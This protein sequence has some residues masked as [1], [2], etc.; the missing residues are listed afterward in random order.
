MA[1][2][3]ARSP[4]AAARIAILTAAS[5]WAFLAITSPGPLDAQSGAP[6]GW[7]LVYSQDFSSAEAYD[8]FT[9]SDD[10]VWKYGQVLGADGNQG[11][12]EQNS[13]SRYEPKHRS[14][15]YIALIADLLV[16]DFVLEA[17]AWQTGREYG[18]RDLSL[19]F[20]FEGP[21]RYYYAHLATEPDERAHNI[22]LVDNADRA[23]LAAVPEDGVDWGRGWKRVRLERREGKIRVYF[24]GAAEPTLSTDKD[25]LGWGRLG[26]GSFDDTGRFTNIRV[27]APEARTAE[28][29]AFE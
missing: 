28:E 7:E 23:P 18:H 12:L 10:W 25:P 26:F 20:A 14:P 11:F 8:D 29:P 22:F 16:H 15:L 17:D 1:G 2:L 13:G 5:A 19:F 27:W 24:D 9:F 3:G 21:N 4:R 6:D